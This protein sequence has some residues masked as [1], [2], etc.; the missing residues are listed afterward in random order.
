MDPLDRFAFSQSSLQ[1]FVDCQRRFKLR[2]L[3]HI[4]WPAIQAEPA[5]ENER[6]IQ[7]GQRFHHLAQQYLSGVPADRLTR[8]A[9]TDADE[10]L[11]RWWQ[12][13][14]EIIPTQ[15]EGARFVEVTL[16]APLGVFRLEA[17]YDLVLLR[18]DG[19]ALIFD[20]KTSQ[21][22]PSRTWLLER[23]QTR[24]YPYL[25]AQAGASLNHGSAIAPESIEM[26]Y[27]FTEPDQPPER[28]A[29]STERY[30]LDGR[31]LRG[32]TETIRSLDPDHFNMAETDQPC[33]YCV[34]R[35]LCDRGVK[36]GDMA[37]SEAYEP[38]EPGDLSFDLEQIGEISF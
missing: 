8:M 15:L 28:L 30:E 25:L 5:H 31:Y 27:W 6:F 11:A 20:W 38:A 17:I 21:R 4:A 19:Q 37:A 23:L 12:N 13:F 33:S 10:N 3:Q 32:L 24:V 29:Y 16:E 35:S 18:P 9:E 34:Y 2:Y 7:R 14:L 1:D 22:R 26:I 36:A